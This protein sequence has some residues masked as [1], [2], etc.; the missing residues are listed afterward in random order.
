MNNC[1]NC[2]WLA[3]SPLKNGK[4]R[5]Y[6]YDSYQCTAPIPDVRLP[7]SVIKSYG[8]SWPPSKK[9][10]GGDDGENCPCHIVRIK[11]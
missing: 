1:K 5:I 9:W 4:I 7:H 11:N 8:F 3:V 2:G 10:V 6:K